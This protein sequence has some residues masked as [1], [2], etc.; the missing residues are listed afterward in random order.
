MF[1][2]YFDE[3]GDD[4]FP[5]YSSP[6]FVL[7][8]IYFH[9]SEWQN[10]YQNLKTKRKDIKNK[11]GFPINVELH[12]KPFLL[13]KRPYKNFSIPD[14]LRVD[15]IEDYIQ[16]IASLNLKCVNVAINKTLINTPVNKVLDWAVTYATQRLEN[17]LEINNPDCNFMIITDPGRVGKMRKTT[18]RIQVFNPIPSRVSPGLTY[19]REIHRLLEDPL[20][21]ESDQSYFIQTADVIS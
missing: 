1:L 4:G 5:N 10:L 20:E 3:S 6:L 16:F 13:N 8:A 19:R 9:N 14:N 2:S 7:S 18:R 17:D 21:K 12:A 11:Y 15:L